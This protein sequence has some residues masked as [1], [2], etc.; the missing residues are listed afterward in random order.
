MNMPM[1]RCIAAILA[2][3][4]MFPA[5]AQEYVPTK[6]NIEAR[7]AFA[8]KRFGVFIHWGIYSMF[9]QGEW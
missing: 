1:K 3:A 4:A 6:E 2:A 7:E 8:D 5:L 9:A